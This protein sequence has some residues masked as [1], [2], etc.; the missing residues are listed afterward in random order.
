[1]EGRVVS[2]C[3]TL[4]GIRPW[5]GLCTVIRVTATRTLL[6]GEYEIVGK[7]ETRYYICSLSET[8]Q[9]FARAN[10]C[11]LGSGKQSPLCS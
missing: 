8:A 1:V 11:L 6:K 10:S 9:Q 5:V 3:R 2:I 4:E 7:P